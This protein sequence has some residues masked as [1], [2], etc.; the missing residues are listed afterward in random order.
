M[1]Q[2]F[3]TRALEAK[4][5]KANLFSIRFSRMWCRHFLLWLKKEVNQYGYLAPFPSSWFTSRG[6]NFTT[7]HL[8]PIIFTRRARWLDLSARALYPIQYK[9]HND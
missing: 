7:Y 1:K 6:A 5:P 4:L 3:V 9:Q 2:H 8:G